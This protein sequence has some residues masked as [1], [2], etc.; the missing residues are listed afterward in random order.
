LIGDLARELLAVHALAC[1]A[2]VADPVKLAAW[3]IRL[4]DHLDDMSDR[5]LQ[6]LHQFP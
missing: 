4:Q 6:Q 5:T 2:G 1:D 3:M